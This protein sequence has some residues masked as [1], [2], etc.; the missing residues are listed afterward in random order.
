VGKKCIEV[1][2]HNNVEVVV[3]AQVC[4]GMPQLGTGNYD[5]TTKAVDTNTEMLKQFVDEGYTIVTPGPS[6][7]YMM[8]QEYPHFATDTESANAIAR[9]TTDICEY[10]MSLNDKKKLKMDFTAVREKITYHLPC[11]LRAQNIGFKSRDLMKL[12]PGVEI[13]M[14]QQCSGHDG[15]WSMKKEYYELSLEV[16]KKLANRI[17]REMPATVASDCL[18]A[19]LHIDEMTHE[20]AKHPIEIIHAAYGL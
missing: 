19:H 12:I 1:L 14:V 20:Q 18:L 11:H 9:N 15:S 6:C 10:L 4:C 2:E 17:E 7:G 8:R 5:A 13:E 16:G 3:P